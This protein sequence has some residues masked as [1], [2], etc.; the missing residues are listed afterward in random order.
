MLLTIRSVCNV[1]I[2]Y[3]NY[4][5]FIIFLLALLSI[6]LY[7][8]ICNTAHM[9]LTVCLLHLSIYL[10]VFAISLSVCLSVCPIYLSV[11]LSICPI[12]AHGTP[13]SRAKPTFSSKPTAWPTVHHRHNHQRL[14]VKG[15]NKGEGDV[16]PPPL[17]LLSPPPFLGSAYHGFRNK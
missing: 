15:R 12:T 9:S 17:P 11:C 7:I 14:T 3:L 1:S 8:Y 2:M 5:H 4:F 10:S 13:I 6:Y 16:S